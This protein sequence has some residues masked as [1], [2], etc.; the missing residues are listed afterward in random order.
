[1]TIDQAGIDFIKVWEGF[2]ANVYED[3]AGKRTIGIGH[4]I[5]PSEDFPAGITIRQAEELLWHDLEAPELA[6]QRLVPRSCTQNQW[7][8]LCSFAFNLGVGALE[9]M[10]AHGWS[11]VSVQIPRWSHAGRVEV[12]GLVRR[13]AAEVKLFNTV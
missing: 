3:V 10:L 9:E 1:M 5:L 6:L 2:S 8:A 12:P 7:N 13:R 4:L 11:E